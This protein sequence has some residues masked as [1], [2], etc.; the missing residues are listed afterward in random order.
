MNDLSRAY[1]ARKIVY[2]WLQVIG[3]LFIA[4]H[5]PVLS[6]QAATLNG[7]WIQGAMVIGR[8][9]P[10]ETVKY[11]GQTLTQSAQGDFVFGLGRNAPAVVQLQVYAADGSQKTLS[12]TVAQR[13]YAIQKIEGVASKH[14]TPPQSV[15]ERI[16][17]EASAVRKARELNAKRTDFLTA[18]IW[19]AKG[20]IT[21]VYG[22]QRVYNGVPKNPH[23]GV[24][25]AGPVGTQ[26]IA[27]AAGV[28][29]FVSDDL[30]YSGGTL[31]IDHGHGISSTFIHLSK[32]EV[33][34]GQRV[35]QGEL[36]ARMGA[37]GRATGPHLDWR[38]NWFNERIDPQLLFAKGSKPALQ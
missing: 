35:L 32:V 29:T 9:E 17:R 25:I 18:F 22:S 34:L 10:G 30:Y 12:Y 7:P 38:M 36:I 24:D 14:V 26:V 21:G 3:V 4:A 6:V 16:S 2:M 8:A 19:P 27:P 28:V 13:E 31:I 5:V 23:Y 33:A 37:S 11:N 1:G 15:T 20:P